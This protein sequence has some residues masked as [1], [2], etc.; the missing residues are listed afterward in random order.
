MLIREKSATAQRKGKAS[1]YYIE[2]KQIP[3]FDIQPIL[4]SEL[5]NV[6]N[7]VFSV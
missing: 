2:W 4:C 6:F 1:P 7:I 3:F 5:T